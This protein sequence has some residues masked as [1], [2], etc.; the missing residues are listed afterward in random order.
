MAG[1]W[2]K[3]DRDL[4]TKPAVIAIA[5]ATKLE[6]EHVVGK[7]HALWSWADKTTEDGFVPGATLAWVNK[8]VRAKR[9][10]ETMVEFGWLAEKEGGI[11]FL[12]Y[13]KHNGKSGR[14]RALENQRQQKHRASESAKVSRRQR[15]GLRDKNVTPEPEEE[16]EEIPN[17]KPNLETD[18]HPCK[19]G[20]VSKEREGGNWPGSVTANDLRDPAK[21]LEVI[22][23]APAELQSEEGRLRIAGAAVRALEKG[24][25]P[26]A[27]FVSLLK[28]R[29]WHFITQEQEDQA[30]EML[31]AAQPRPS[32][33]VVN[34]NLFQAPEPIR[35]RAPRD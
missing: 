34:V 3:M 10:A 14:K 35:E 9:F 4:A 17:T 32:L 15:D 30:R 7:L 24:R 29:Q 12:D 16:L 26:V 6:E 33:S 21:L 20:S 18:A 8:F 13:H 5:L 23:Q 1:E 31:R 22:R 11:E 28:R 25:K 27:M 2:I 19:S